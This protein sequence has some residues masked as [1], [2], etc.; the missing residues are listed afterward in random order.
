MMKMDGES[1]FHIAPE[2]SV[3]YAPDLPGI[4]M[5]WRGYHTSA[6]FRAQNESVLATLAAHKAS[7]I[8]CDIR[9]F[10]LIGAE[11]QVW[12]NGHWLP[13]AIEAGLCHAAIVTP[14]YFFNRVAV[15]EVVQRLDSNRLR[16]EYFE[17]TE[18]A[19]DWLRGVS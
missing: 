8:L 9:H 12:L 13:R 4:V 16:V 18:A 5:T 1:L 11:D 3:G 17:A 15:G 2:F 10:L 7:K 19:R 14:L 6:S